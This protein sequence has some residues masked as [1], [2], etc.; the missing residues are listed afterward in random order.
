MTNATGGLLGVLDTYSGEVIAKA[1]SQRRFTIVTV[2][3]V[4]SRAIAFAFGP[5]GSNP[6]AALLGQLDL[7]TAALSDLGQIT[8]SGT[9]INYRPRCKPAH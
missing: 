5:S 4:D 1:T 9:A 2:N 7:T 6:L 3:P 8:G